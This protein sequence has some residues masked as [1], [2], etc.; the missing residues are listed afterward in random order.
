MSMALVL[1]VLKLRPDHVGGRE[2]PRPPP[3]RVEGNQEWYVDAILR[4]QPAKVPTDK[5][6]R[7]LVSWVGYP[8]EDA[9]WRPRREIEPLEAFDVYIGNKKKK[10]S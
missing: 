8:L 7:Y 2:Q 3:M 5:G 6:R 1:H 9:E 4:H 10:E